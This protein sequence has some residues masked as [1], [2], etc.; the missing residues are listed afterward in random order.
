MNDELERFGIGRGI[1][2]IW[3]W[4]GNQ[5]MLELKCEIHSVRRALDEAMGQGPIIDDEAS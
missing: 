2:K 4:K 3:D 5:N 1:A